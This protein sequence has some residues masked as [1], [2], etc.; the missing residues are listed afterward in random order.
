LA[1][2][3]A[4]E[5][6]P[7]Q[8]IPQPGASWQPSGEPARYPHQYVRGGTV[9]LLT[10][11]HPATG[12]L[13]VKGVTHTP[14]TVLHPWLQQELTAITAALP[15]LDEIADAAA[16]RAAW[17]RWQ[18]GLSVRFTLL[19]ALPPLRVLLIL[20]NLAGHKSATFVC[21]LMAHGIMPLYTPISGSGLNRA[22]SIQRILVGRALAGQHPDSP[23]QLMEWLEAVARG[24]N[25]CPTPF[26][27]GGKRALR[28]QRARER[29]YGL[30]GSGAV[31]RQPIPHQGVTINGDQQGK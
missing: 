11:F 8:A 10:L 26:I 30:G 2:W 19:E 29:R 3:C 23:T 7:Y 22:E 15:P 25:A 18:A 31:S 21:W 16:N 24:W 13:R 20:D 4:D 28:R 9:K 14:N 5:A 6:G 17:A 12:Q 1:V 27:G